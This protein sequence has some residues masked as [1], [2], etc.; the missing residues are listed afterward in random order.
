MG[1][2]EIRFHIPSNE[3]AGDQDPVEAFK[4]AVMKK[5]SVMNTTGDAIAILNE[6][7]CLSPRGNLVIQLAY[8][9]LSVL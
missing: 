2:S 1:L 3:A 8:A 4:E 7:S 6:V 9:Q 5:A